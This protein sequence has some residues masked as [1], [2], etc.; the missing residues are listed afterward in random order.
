MT[1]IASSLDDLDHQPSAVTIGNFDGVHRGHQVLL[2]RAVQA[3]QQLGVRSV[4]VTFDPHPAAVLR[5]DAAPPQLQSLEA[6]IQAL[7]E[8]GVDAVLVLPFTPRLAASSPSEFVADVLAS[9]LQSVKVVVGTNFRFGA[10]AAG[11]VVTL[12]ELG[13]IHGFVPEAVT[14]LEIDG[15]R[16]SSS[17]VREHLLDGDLAWALAALGRP[18]ELPGRVVAGEGRGRRIGFPTANL[19]VPDDLVVPAFGVYAGHVRL[20]GRVH[21]AV[22]NVGV[23]P[24]FHG[25][26]RTIEAHLLDQELDLYGRDLTVTFE[27]RI[28]GERRFDGPDELVARIRMDVDQARG[29]LGLG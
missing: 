3:G 9:Q 14:L 21:P 12:V 20:D 28:R 25:K 6:R 24:T 7:S 26:E 17:A 11:D 18:H 15:R 23:R 10:K 2:R 1:E 16:I 13:E 5:P 8:T 19:A 27:H 22:T 4:A 29:L